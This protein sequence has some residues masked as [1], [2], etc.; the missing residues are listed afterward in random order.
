MK[1]LITGAAGFIGFSLAKK[2]LD[3]SYEVI[4]IDN[5]NLYYDPKLK[6]DRLKLIFLTITIFIKK[7]SK[8]INFLQCL[9]LQL[10]LV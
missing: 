6:R 8:N 3:L 10:K 7:F 2:F 4:G 5:I 1:L 9:I